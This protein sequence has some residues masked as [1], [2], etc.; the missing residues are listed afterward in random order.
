MLDQMA[1]KLS[2]DRARI[3]ATGLSEGGFM[4]MKVGGAMAGRIA[5][6]APTGA[7]MPQTMICVPSRPVPVVMINGTSDSSPHVK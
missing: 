6:I 7:A 4:A 3:H 1:T 2:V 5:A